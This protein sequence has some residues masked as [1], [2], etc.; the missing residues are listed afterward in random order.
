MSMSSACALLI[1]AAR[2]LDHNMLGRRIQSWAFWVHGNRLI[3]RSD[4]MPN[5]SG[6]ILSRCRLYRNQ[7]TGD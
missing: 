4:L 2:D 7:A 3:H 5:Q 6:N 1:V